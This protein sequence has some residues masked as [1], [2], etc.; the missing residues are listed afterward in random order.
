MNFQMPKKQY[1]TQTVSGK[2]AVAEKRKGIFWYSLDDLFDD[3]HDA[4]KR[5]LERQMQEFQSAMDEVWNAGCEAG[6]FA[7]HE[8]RGDYLC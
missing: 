6:H 1:V 3:K 5:M 7:Y 2:W 8:D 4:Q